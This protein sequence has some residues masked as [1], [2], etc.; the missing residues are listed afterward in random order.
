MG[1]TL[2]AIEADCRGFCNAQQIT[3]LTRA[4]FLAAVNDAQRKW[5]DVVRYPEAWSMTSPRSLSTPVRTTRTC[6]PST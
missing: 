5:C 1:L 3:M 2:A 4:I 6:R